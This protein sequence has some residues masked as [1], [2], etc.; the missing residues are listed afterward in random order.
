MSNVRLSEMDVLI[1]AARKTFSHFPEQV[2]SHW[3]D[4]R[5]RE[6]GWPPRGE[7]WWSFLA[8]EPVSFWQALTWNLTLIPLNAGELTQ[9]SWNTIHA[10][11]EVSLQ[12]KKNAISSYLPDTAARFNSL[13]SYVREHRTIPHPVILLKKESGFHIVDG[14]HR[15]AVVLALQYAPNSLSLA[16]AEIEAWVASRE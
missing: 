2:S 10:M 15:I 11:L 16:P 14:H 6:K 13:L 4:D 3:L 7:E 5:V 1:N 8:G 12:G 9:E